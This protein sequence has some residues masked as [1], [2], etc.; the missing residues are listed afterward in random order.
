MAKKPTPKGEET[1]SF[2]VLSMLRFSGALYGPDD[3]VE[4]APAEAEPLVA[5][6]VLA[7]SPAD[8]AKP[9]KPPAQ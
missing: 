1:Q 9:A 5:A 4:M 2:A 7:A 3:M 6:G 8:P